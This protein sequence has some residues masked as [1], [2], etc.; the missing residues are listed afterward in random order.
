M[1]DQDTAL[2]QEAELETAIPSTPEVEEQTAGEDVEPKAEA[3]V[4][5]GGEATET[6][7]EPKKGAEA[8]I[9]ELNS[10]AKQ[11]E[12]RAK[13]LEQQLAEL[14]G[15]PQF[16]PNQGLYNPQFEP[17]SEI[18][19]NTLSQQMQRT[20][21]S[22]AQLI[23]ANERNI[24]RINKESQEVIKKFKMLDPDAEDHFDQDLS[25]SVTEATMAFIKA[26]PTGSVKNFVEKLMKPYQ[27][28]VT[29][30]VG[31]ARAEIAKQV[32]EAAT[33][34]STQVKTSKSPAEK[35]I[36]ELEAELGFVS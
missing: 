6:V 24:A 33:R 3:T 31:Q 19:S 1:T 2:N 23:A 21:L 34:P 5:A 35:T 8:R 10:R 28:S 18:D 12:E 13:S 26:N 25:E 17:G 20:A 32:S 7:D 11:A 30:E 16:D 9:R 36:K 15:V 14:S 4:E 29:K 27:R 22:A